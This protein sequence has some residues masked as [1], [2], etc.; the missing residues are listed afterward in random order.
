LTAKAPVGKIFLKR[1]CPYHL[2]WY[3]RNTKHGPLCVAF[4]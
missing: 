2:F 4:A 3:R 1:D